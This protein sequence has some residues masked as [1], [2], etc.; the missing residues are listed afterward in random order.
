MDD[1]TIEV[2]KD[3]EEEIVVKRR[4]ITIIGNGHE[5]KSSVSTKTD[6]Q[7]V[8][9][10]IDSDLKL[11]DLTIKGVDIS[12]TKIGC[13]I[14][15]IDSSVSLEKVQIKDFTTTTKMMNEL[16]F[17]IGFYICNTKTSKCQI[18][19]KNTIFSNIYYNF[20]HIENL[21]EQK[22]DIVPAIRIKLEQN[23]LI[24]NFN[25]EEPQIGIILMGNVMGSISNTIFENFTCQKNSS[26]G[27]YMY[28]QQNQI[29][30]NNN[31]FLAVQKSI[32]QQ[33]KR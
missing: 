20:I 25:N 21:S 2:I 22:G 1:L 16:P 6:K 33:F 31:Q 9:T 30:L 18:D 24:G 29:T 3:I 11:I 15:A 28:L 14:K 19:I 10:V 5:I 13:G 4:T 32:Y 26:Y 12:K 27:I 23:H 8:I 17:G 7:A